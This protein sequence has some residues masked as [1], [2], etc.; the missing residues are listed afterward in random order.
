MHKDRNCFVT[1]LQTPLAS[2]QGERLS[3]ASHPDQG[4]A[5]PELNLLLIRQTIT[6]QVHE[7][8]A[9]GGEMLY[10]RR[11]SNKIFT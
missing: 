8:R 5:I 7:T 6:L 10:D 3:M 9:L 2:S 1:G 4:C 11:L